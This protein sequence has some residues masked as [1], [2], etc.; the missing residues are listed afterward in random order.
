MTILHQVPS[1]AKIKKELRRLVFGPFL[2]CP[3]CQ[4]RNIRPEGERY[5]C[6][7]CHKPFSLISATWLKG[8]KMPLS[9]F[10]LLLWAWLNKNPVDQ[11]MK[12]TG[13]SLPTVRNWYQKFRDRLPEPSQ[14]ELRLGQNVQIDEAY[15]RGYAILG[16]KEMKT[17]KVIL[18][19]LTK[20]SVDRRDAVDFL[21]QHVIP[22]SNL[23]S[24]GA[25]IYKT[26]DHW[27]PINHQAE[28]HK[29]FQFALTSEIEGLWGNYFTFVRR[30]YHHVTF[31]QVP[32]LLKEFSARFSHAEWF[33]SPQK[34]L[35]LTIKPMR[36]NRGRLWIKFC[37]KIFQTETAENP[38]FIKLKLVMPVPSC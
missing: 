4:S 32:S 2:F 21:A 11:A 26:I 1:L 22:G 9:T 12:L 5:R 27:W 34:Y 18:E 13:L 6:R 31:Q 25:S 15:R 36:R 24:D 37:R 35:A 23:F 30:M 28:Y 8:M 33:I 20:D 38:L 19:R 7:R 29:R 10:W 14:S 3:R 16:A 17:R